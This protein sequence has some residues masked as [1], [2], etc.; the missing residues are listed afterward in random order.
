MK[1]RTYKPSW[2]PGPSSIQ[3]W[4][5]DAARRRGNTLQQL[6]RVQVVPELSRE[7]LAA[8]YRDSDAFVLPSRGEGWC[9]PCMEAMSSGLPLLTT[10]YS[11]PSAFMSDQNAY[12]IQVQRV[13]PTTLQAEPDAWHLQ[14]QMRR[15]CTDRATAAATGRQAR[16]DVISRFSAEHVAGIVVEKLEQLAQSA[17]R[18]TQPNRRA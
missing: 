5:Q 8:L 7:S 12:P 9:L 6:P 3:L 18:S 10:N 4:L 14:S 16:A 15:V 13:D 1:L 11:G 17:D 2:E